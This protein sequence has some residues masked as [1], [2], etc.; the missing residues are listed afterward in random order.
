MTLS[1]KAV[2]AIAFAFAVMVRAD[3][4]SQELAIPEP[5]KIEHHELFEALEGAIR[6]GG[7]T[8]QAALNVMIVLKPHFEK[9]EKFALPQL[10]ALENLTKQGASISPAMRTDLIARTETFR[11]ELPAMLQEHKQIGAAL[12]E[13]EHA[14]KAENKSSIAALA[15]KI[16]AHAGMEEK[17]LYPTALLVGESAKLRDGSR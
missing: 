3:A 17:I 12:V 8:G 1:Y 2:F 10:G 14:A 16:M 15:E 4:R 6:S 7:S 11:A 13:M 5:L 9:E